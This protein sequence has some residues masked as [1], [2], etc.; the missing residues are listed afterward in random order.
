MNRRAFDD[1]NRRHHPASARYFHQRSLRKASPLPPG[2]GL[3]AALVEL[4][5]ERARS[6]GDALEVLRLATPEILRALV[7]RQFRSA[8]LLDLP[9]GHLPLNPGDRALLESKYGSS[10]IA[11]ITSRLHASSHQTPLEGDLELCHGASL[12]EVHRWANCMAAPPIDASRRR[13]SGL[14]ILLLR[15]RKG[16]HRMA[17][18]DE[19][20]GSRRF[21]DP[22]AGEIVFSG[23]EGFA[24]W[25]VEF[26]PAGGYARRS[27]DVT[28]YRF[29]PLAAEV[30]SGRES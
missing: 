15:Y 6:G 16:G 7:M 25:F 22:N 19:G 21:F 28:L 9:A 30:T 1:L 4:W 8:Y 20:G 18:I 12:G 3:C 29:K 13:D 17:F 27:P 14:R 24:E 23:E 10:D 5:W 11:L 2:F 26:W